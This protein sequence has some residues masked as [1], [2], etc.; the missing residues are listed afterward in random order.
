MTATLVSVGAMGSVGCGWRGASGRA[1]SIASARRSVV[2]TSE[3]GVPGSDVPDEIG[4]P[5]GED[6][7]VLASSLMKIEPDLRQTLDHRKRLRSALALEGAASALNDDALDVDVARERRHE[8]HIA[9]G[10]RVS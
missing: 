8:L 9:L 6:S 10:H 7:G 4:P 5:S 3:P 2:G 1:S